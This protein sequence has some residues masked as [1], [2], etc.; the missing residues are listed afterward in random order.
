MAPTQ[1]LSKLPKWAQDAFRHMQAE[2]LRLEQEL[3]QLRYNTTSRIQYGEGLGEYH[4]IPEG[5]HIRFELDTPYNGK[6]IMRQVEVRIGEDPDYLDI[7]GYDTLLIEPR[8]ANSLRI[9]IKV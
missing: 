3:K 9:R 2:N 7:Q 1:D 4:F 5:A 6:S 8:A